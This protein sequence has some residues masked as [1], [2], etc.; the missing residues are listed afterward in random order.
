[1]KNKLLLSSAL[2]GSLVIGSSAYS[3]TSVTGN[4]SLSYK[5]LSGYTVGS[6]TSAGRS[7]GRESQIN[8]QNKGKLNNGMD[9]AA[10]FSLENDGGQET[11]LSNENVFIDFISGDTTLSIGLDHIQNT[12]RTLGNLVGN[13][14]FDLNTGNNYATAA[15]TQGF[16][17][18]AGKDVHQSMGVGIV[19]KTPIGSISA[20]YTPT[21]AN[22]GSDNEVGNKAGV[23]T[24]TLESDRESAFEFGFVGNLGVKGLSA[25]AFYNEEGKNAGQA[26]DTK[27]TNIGVSYNFGQIT[28]GYTRKENENPGT[29]AA[30]GTDLTQD[31]FGIAFAATPNVTL[32]AN[33]TKS[34]SSAA[35]TVDAKSKSVSVGYNLGPVAIIG[36]YAKQE[37]TT[38]TTATGD[39]DVAFIKINTNF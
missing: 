2:L 36:Q 7:F 39:V 34:D 4:L 25:H 29:T 14:A 23:A 18:S 6:A 24:T 15:V 12:N 35:A 9:Y 20:F 21:V 11:D 27:G 28:A 13:D 8:V 3:Q 22:T 17:Q 5:A 26:R 33:Y 16:I 32:G 1:M 10:G 38:N 31:E 30:A 19:Q 37:N